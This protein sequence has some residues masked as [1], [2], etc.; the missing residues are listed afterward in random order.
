MLGYSVVSQIND[1]WFDPATR[2]PIKGVE[3]TVSP[4][5]GTG[6]TIPVLIPA[7]QYANP[8]TVKSLL[9]AAVDHYAAVANL[10]R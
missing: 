4:A 8:D 5:D 9:D 1:T 7:A 10:G 6:S 3:V 2:A